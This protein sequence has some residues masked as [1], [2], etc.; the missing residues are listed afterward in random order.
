MPIIYVI[1]ETY[2]PN[3]D[4]HFLDKD[5]FIQFMKSDMENIVNLDCYY[6]D[7]DKQTLSLERL[8]TETI[9]LIL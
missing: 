4:I 9:K 5:A 1:K 6:I 3:Q 8:H 2:M 7:T